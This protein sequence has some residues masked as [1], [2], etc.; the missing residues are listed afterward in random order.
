MGLNQDA[1]VQPDGT[2]CEQVLTDVALEICVK[3]FLTEVSG[4]PNR[5]PTQSGC[6]YM[7]IS[8]ATMLGK[9]VPTGDL[10]VETADGATHRLGDGVG[11]RLG[12]R[13]ADRAVERELLLNPALSLGEL[14]MD[15]RLI[16]TRGSLY[17]ILELGARNLAE[18]EK[19]P[20][21]KTLEK[22]RAAFRGV[23]RRNDRGR[24]KTNVARHYDHDARL[25]DLFL[26][27]DHQYSCAYFEHLVQSLDEA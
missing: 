11:P 25:Y 16:V 14:Y 24:A 23:D 2:R 18:I 21:A 1:A 9:L 19:L 20:W 5:P 17:D 10:E 6:Q 4:R 27:S 7:A 8:L 12:V 13:L 15:G 26:D 22:V 3:P